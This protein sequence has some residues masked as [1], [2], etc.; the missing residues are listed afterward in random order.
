[1]GID[2]LAISVD[3]KTATAKFRQSDRADDVNVSS[4]QT[5]ELVRGNGQWQICK[6]TVGG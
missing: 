2:H 4:R 5:L 6:E 1:V 3:S